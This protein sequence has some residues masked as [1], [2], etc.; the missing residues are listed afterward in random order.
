M[1]VTIS[2]DGTISGISAGG[3]PDNCITADDLAS[4]LDISGKTVT[5]PSDVG[6]ITTGKVLQV[7]SALDSTQR[8]IASTTATDTDIEISITPSSTSSK[9]LLIYHSDVRHDSSGGHYLRWYK[10]GS[11]IGDTYTF[12]I[13]NSGN[14]VPY[15]MTYLDSPATTS[16]VT[17]TLYA[18]SESGGFYYFGFTGYNTL[19]AIEVGA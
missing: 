6:G 14:V 18:H 13:S 8:T 5:L 17:Y 19:L 7:V 10:D 2:G 12:Q 3:L 4:T 11:A 1:A 9:I 15:N 16:E